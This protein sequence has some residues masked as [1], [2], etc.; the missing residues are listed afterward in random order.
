MKTLSC[1]LEQALEVVRTARPEADPN[2][3]FLRQLFLFQTMGLSLEGQTSAHA[4]YR[5]FAAGAEYQRTGSSGPGREW[6]GDLGDGARC[7]GCRRALF[8]RISVVGHGTKDSNSV[9]AFRQPPWQHK[10]NPIRSLSD[11]GAS[12][13]SIF[14]EPMDWMVKASSEAPGWSSSEGKLTCPGCSRKLGS[15]SWGG[16]QCGCGAGV[17]P[18]FRFSLSNIDLPPAMTLN[19]TP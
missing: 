14:V 6:F 17:C 9:V 2:E 5:L 7:K 12:C 19:P 3:G 16:E 8:D 13:S 18:A 4:E 11:N 15:W 10:S 1:P